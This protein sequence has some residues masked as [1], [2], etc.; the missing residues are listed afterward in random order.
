MDSPPMIS[1]G[2]FFS[3]CILPVGLHPPH[4]STPKDEPQYCGV[5]CKL[6]LT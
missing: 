5:V 1:V 6:D 3:S 4:P 2:M